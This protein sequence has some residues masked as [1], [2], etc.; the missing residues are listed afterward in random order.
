[1]RFLCSTLYKIAIHMCWEETTVKLNSLKMAPLDT[2]MCQ[3]EN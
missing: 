1:M 2:E 3:S